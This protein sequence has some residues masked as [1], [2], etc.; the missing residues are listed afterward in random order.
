MAF[1]DLSVIGDVESLINESVADF[2][3]HQN[4]SQLVYQL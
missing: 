2:S 3:L 4:R 1:R